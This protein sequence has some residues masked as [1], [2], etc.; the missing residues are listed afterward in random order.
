[1][2]LE[3]VMHYQRCFLLCPGSIKLSNLLIRASSA[4]HAMGD[5]NTRYK[6]AGSER[7]NSPGDPTNGII[8]FP[9]CIYLISASGSVSVLQPFL[10][11][12]EQLIVRCWFA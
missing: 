6:N 10:E 8:G 4:K 7:I 12:L 5:A 1:M 3:L 11:L 9:K 2:N